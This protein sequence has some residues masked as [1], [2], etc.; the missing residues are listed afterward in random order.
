[1]RFRC[2]ASSVAAILIVFHPALALARPT[3]PSQWDCPGPW[4][5]WSGG[6]GFWWWMP[7]FMLLV[8][9][10][11]GAVFLFGQRMG[12]AHGHWRGRFGDDPT[13]SAMQILNDRFARGEIPRQEFE[14]KRAVLASAQR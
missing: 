11:A 3:Q 9:L 7:L 12:G 10:A 5:M 8:I 4:H 6:P 2:F 14:E 1:M 13:R